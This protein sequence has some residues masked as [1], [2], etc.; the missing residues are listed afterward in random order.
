MLFVKIAFCI[1]VLVLTTVLKRC[2]L[3]AYSHSDG[4]WQVKSA[5]H[6]R[7]Y[8]RNLPIV[9]ILSICIIAALI[10]ELVMNFCMTDL[11]ILGVLIAMEVSVIFSNKISEFIVFT[12]FILGIEIFLGSIISIL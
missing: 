1:A 12:V 2:R 7:I 3:K 5:E 9:I 4:K 10:A 6:A 8:E 11:I